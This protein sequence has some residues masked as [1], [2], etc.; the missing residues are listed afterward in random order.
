M[1]GY[2]TFDNA[3]TM[4]ALVGVQNGGCTSF[5]YLTVTKR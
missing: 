5:W 4:T 1:I 2:G 3:T